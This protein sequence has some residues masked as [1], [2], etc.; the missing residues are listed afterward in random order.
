M[1]VNTVFKDIL[2]RSNEGREIPFFSSHHLRELESLA[3]VMIL[4]GIHG[5]EPEGVELA[6]K[7]LAWLQSATQASEDLVP[8]FA[9]PCL[10]PDGYEKN[11]R[12][13][14][15][16]VD[17]NRN[18]PSKSW[19]PEAKKPRYN[20]GPKPGS[21]IE[22]SS[23]CEMILRLK[24]RLIIHC[25]SWEPCIVATGKPAYTDAHRLGG[26]CGYEVIE[27]IGYDTPGSLSEF[28]WHDNQIP[29]ICIEEKEGTALDQ[30][31]PHFENGIKEIFRDSSN[32]QVE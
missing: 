12:V 20:P 10:N 14:G 6:Q 7:S 17:L 26:S 1:V 24:P 8:W 2:C 28:G 25:H 15:R 27:H 30:V 19:S 13:N 3:P 11:Q 22:I 23:L 31:W 21:E 9:L 5:D 16:G 18:Y 29:I 32:R 4:G